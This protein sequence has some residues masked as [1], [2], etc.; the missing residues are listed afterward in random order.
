MAL[1][2]LLCR[3]A[4]FSLLPNYQAADEEL[5][6]YHKPGYSNRDMPSTPIKRFIEKHKKAK[7]GLLL[8]ALFG[9]CMVISVGVLTP[10]ISGKGTFFHHMFMCIVFFEIFSWTST[11]WFGHHC[12]FMCTFCC[13]PLLIDIWFWQFFHLSKGWNFKR[14]ICLTVSINLWKCRNNTHGNTH[15][16]AY[17]NFITLIIFQWNL[18]VSAYYYHLKINKRKETH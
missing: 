13:T 12:M 14:Q 17:I 7:T 3:N 16:C 4:K 2:A 1:Y 18:K 10:A 15:T 5:S 9:A 8:V 6:K 11:G